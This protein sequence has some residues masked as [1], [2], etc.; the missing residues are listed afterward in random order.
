MLIQFTV[1]SL[2]AYN[3]QVAAVVLIGYGF[4]KRRSANGNARRRLR[5]GAAA[6]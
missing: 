2:A 1:G 4:V 5:R 3:I 6:A